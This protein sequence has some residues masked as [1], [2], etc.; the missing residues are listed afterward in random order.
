MLQLDNFK[1]LSR[2]IMGTGV[3]RDAKLK[4][5][6]NHHVLFFTPLTVLHALMIYLTIMVMLGNI[7]FDGLV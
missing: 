6:M 3:V 4:V 2:A 7:K 5:C 1:S